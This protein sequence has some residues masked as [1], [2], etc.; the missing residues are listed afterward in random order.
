MLKEK[1]FYELIKGLIKKLRH[2]L[3]LFVNQ[4]IHDMAC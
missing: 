3:K 4:N 1:L 2:N